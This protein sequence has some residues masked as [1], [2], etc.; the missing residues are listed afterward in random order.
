LIFGAAAYQLPFNTEGRKRHPCCYLPSLFWADQGTALPQHAK[1]VVSLIRPIS[2]VLGIV[3]RS[4]RKSW[5]THNE[6][7]FS[8]PQFCDG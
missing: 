3:R 8:Q 2:K 6:A 4:A 7:G 1:S 5:A